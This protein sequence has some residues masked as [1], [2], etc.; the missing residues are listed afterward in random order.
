M[1]DIKKLPGFLIVGAPKC[2]TTSLYYYLNKHKKVFIPP[3]KELY[4]FNNYNHLKK[5]KG[6]W[7]PLVISNL[8]SYKKA[9]E[10]SKINQIKGEGTVFYLYEYLRTIANIKKLY[11]KNYKELKIIIMLRNPT[12]RAWSNYIHLRRDIKENLKFQQAINKK[13]IN[14]RLKKGWGPFYDYIGNS[15]Y[16][17]S[18]KY[19]LNTF[20]HVKIILFDDFVKSP[21]RI[22]NEVLSFLELEGIDD[23]T[24]VNK[25]YNKTGEFQ[26]NKRSLN[27]IYHLFKRSHVLKSIL[28][29][30]LNRKK[31]MKIESKF[32]S[33]FSRF[34][35]RKK[36]P[37]E[38]E[39]MIKHY[40]KKDLLK[41]AKLIPEK[42]ETINSWI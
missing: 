11:G 36:M 19:Y 15:L 3:K 29:I 33:F 30:F 35:K 20:K 6:P 21:L 13:I 22:T 37:K 26:T 40:F 18:I 7:K 25:A 4:F 27:L 23:K 31:R 5:Y 2:G 28:R 8:K 42:K 1:I 34:I 17:N 14:T 38:Y 12:A 24:F 10:K 41:L 16:Y 9:F 32:E 39:K